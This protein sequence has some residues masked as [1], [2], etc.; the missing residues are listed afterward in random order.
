VFITPSLATGLCY[1]PPTVPSINV[2]QYAGLWYQIAEDP[3][4]A[5]TTERGAV[6]ATANYT[7]LENGTIGVFN[8]ARVK[9]VDGPVET[10]SGY[11]EIQDKNYP[12][13][14]TVHLRGG[15][16][17]GAPYWILLLGPVVKNQY[18]YAVVSD[19]LCISL[20]VLSRT[21]SI[22]SN[23]EVEIKKYLSAVGFDVESQY[24]P[25]L[26]DGCNYV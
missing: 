8:S 13:R 19:N 14:L 21:P 6:C 23:T 5:N 7:L 20:F 18:S 12:G 15:V 24:V 22:D 2:P 9:T 1:H 4:V 3:F 17:L 25:V 26:Q 10:I 11:A 16:P